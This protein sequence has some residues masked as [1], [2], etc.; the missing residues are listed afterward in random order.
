MPESSDSFARRR[1]LSLAGGA[2]SLAACGSAQNAE[3][4]AES[5]ADVTLRIGEITVDLAP[6]RAVKTIGYNGQTPGPLLR[7]PEG[8]PVT[9]DVFNQTR[10]PEIVHWHGLHIP[11][12]VDGSHEEGTPYV[13]ARGQ[14]RYMFTP[15]PAGTRWYHSHVGAG[16]NLQKAT[17]S[18]QFGTLIVEPR[19]DPGRYDL[20]VPLLLHEW[21]PYWDDDGP[22]S[23]GYKV[24]SVNGKMLG[25]GEPVRVRSGQQ[26]LFRIVNAS[27]TLAHRLALPGHRFRVV[28][29]DGNPVPEPRSVPILELGPAER[30][31]AVVEMSYPGI[32]VLGST[33]ERR[34]AA[35]MG[36]VIE[37]DGATGPPRWAS[38]PTPIWDYTVFGGQHPSAPPEGRV[39]LVFKELSGHRW[40]INGK[41]FPKTDPIMV[42]AN[43]RY[44]WIFDNQSAD[45]HPLHLHRHTFE[46]I[47]VAEKPTS[48]LMKDVVMVP[49]W[50]EVEVDVTA[51]HPGPTLFHCHQQFHM[52][53][54]F[55][56]MMLYKEEGEQG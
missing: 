28:A 46:L 6:R 35:G 4:A 51:D 21:D 31:D 17:Y 47:R 39:N 41:S 15:T 55:M 23:V 40:T 48:G 52:D 26:I 2:L 30:I 49:A 29:L 9:I 36:I 54:G 45:P 42:Q 3:A 10:E 44:R 50:K 13:P 20:E 5:P 53:F 24:Y 38:T 22:R 56:A 34:R 8:K 12:D 16:H 33:D 27:A 43:R 1:F 19:S 32:W 25:A 37:Y 11:S 18:G 14:R 7:L